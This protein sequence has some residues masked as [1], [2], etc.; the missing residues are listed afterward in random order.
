[1]VKKRPQSVVVETC[2]TGVTQLIKDVFDVMNRAHWHQ[3][4][5]L[6][7]RS[8]RM[9]DL[10]GGRLRYAAALPYVWWG[11][12]V[13]DKK[14]GLRRIDTLRQ[15]PAAMRFLSI[16][17]LLEDLGPI[18]LTGI[19]WV[20]VGGESGPGARPCWVPDVRNLVRQCKRA[21][22]PAFVKQLGANVQDRNDAGWDGYEPDEWPDQILAEDRVEHLEEGYQGAPVRV[23][24]RDRKGG[25][26]A[27]WPADLRVRQMPEVN[28]G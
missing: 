21:G 12:S 17:P 4:Q 27:E 3:Y 22:V 18:D 23:H 5:V 14:Y 11:V 19:D 24:L 13:E 15:V 10:L 9:R 25:D 1:M 8:E 20:I 28:R 26:P 6:T 2:W 7:K 16:E